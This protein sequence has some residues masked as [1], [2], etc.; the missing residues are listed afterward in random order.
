VRHA[1]AGHE[2]AR[3]RR[4]GEIGGQRIIHDTSDAGGGDRPCVRAVIG[5]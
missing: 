1:P 4:L 5:V 2:G 3:D